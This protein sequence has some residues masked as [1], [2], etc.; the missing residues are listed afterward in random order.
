[1]ADPNPDSLK[2]PFRAVVDRMLHQNAEERKQ[3]EDRWAKGTPICPYCEV[4]LVVNDF[5]KRT[6][7]RTCGDP[8]CVDLMMARDDD[9]RMESCAVPPRYQ[10][11]VLKDFPEPTRKIIAEGLKDGRSWF[12]TGG[13]GT[14]K[15]HLAAAI[16]RASRLT[17][18][19]STVPDLLLRVRS[20]F[21][22]HADETEKEIVNYYTG[23]PMLVLDDLGAEK[24]TDWS[25]STLYVIVNRRIDALKPTVVT[26]NLDLDKLAAFDPR[27][28][29]R[30]GGF[31]RVKLAGRDRRLTVT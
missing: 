29:S 8:A 31:C 3:E 18:C 2:P 14:G 15:T 10:H 1:M 26:S 5:D 24:V 9:N 16:F 20:T 4:A 19:W 21:R 30:L 27:L 22:D 13:T 7:E 23:A 12:L 6:R 17:G 28:A 11:A 25:L